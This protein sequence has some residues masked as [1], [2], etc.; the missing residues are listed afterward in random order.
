M[1]A[2]ADINNPGDERALQSWLWQ[3]T[4]RALNAPDSD[5]SERRQKLLDAYLGQPYGDE[6]D[7]F[8][9]VVTREVLEAVEWSMPSLTRVFL[10]GSC[11]VTFSPVGEEDRERARQESEY[12]RWSLAKT[13]NWYENCSQWI[14]AALTYPNS[15]AKLWWE[16]TVEGT[17][18]V[19]EGQ[20]ELQLAMLANDPDTDIIGAASRQVVMLTEQGEVAVEVFDITCRHAQTRGRMQFA[21]V[22]PEEVLLDNDIALL[23][24]DA[25]EWTCHHRRTPRT[26]L[27][28][29]GF[30]RDM[31]L[32]LPTA[33][34]LEYSSERENRARYH[35]EDPHYSDDFGMMEK[36]DLYES[37]GC[38]DFD[39][40]G[41]AEYRRMM[42]AGS[43][44]KHGSSILVNEPIDY[45][46][47]LAL[48]TIPQ[49]YRHVG[50]PLAELT[51][52]IQ[53]VNSVVSRQSLDNLYRTNRPR[54]FADPG[55]NINIEQLMNYAP[56]G[57][58]EAHPDSVRAEVL[59]VV[60]QQCLEAVRHWKE[61]GQARTGISRATM[62]LDAEVLA[63]STMGAFMGAI[64]Q[65]S[66]REEQI[67]R[68]FAETGFTHLYRKAHHLCRTHQR[69]SDVFQL[70]GKWVP[71]DPRDW[72]ERKQVEVKVGTGTGTKQERIGAS[73]AL[74]DVQKEA[75]SVGMTTP[76]RIF[77]TLEDMTAAMGKQD[78]NR[79]FLDPSSPEYE[80][81]QDQKRQQAEDE[82]RR[83][84]SQAAALLG[85][86]QE[87]T[88]ARRASEMEG[89][90]VDM[91]KLR[92]DAEKIADASERWRTEAEL[93]HGQNVPGAAV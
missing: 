89:T 66:A 19:Y 63:K 22:P 82:R 5:L 10:G 54:Q 2:G 1:A 75:L 46:P 45:Q 74:L 44:G 21:A 52:D 28:Q 67:I 80:Q 91:H 40:D 62:G 59:P 37:W 16:T 9:R 58:V 65:A 32:G 30:D 42:F 15:Y 20:T 6:E 93:K 73:M 47:M 43:S 29:M 33:E 38:Y 72:Y 12:V 35:D 68:D 92:N 50:V 69:A 55:A 39:G 88:R 83:A 36:V 51:E 57:V 34:N 56:F 87:K 31:V 84:E 23:N 24:L 25:S 76:S 4:D 18:A 79:Y 64:G 86:E 14:R 11:P 8:S 27:V 48:S 90:I 26:E 77:N 78:V 71:V 85:V 7:G 49:P 61:E 53:R 70:R 13:D 3:K 81:A 60:L 17:V 41:I